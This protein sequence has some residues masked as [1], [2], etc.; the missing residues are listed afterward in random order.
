M[1]EI[2]GCMPGIDGGTPESMA[3]GPSL[4][5]QFLKPNH[6]SSSSN[7]SCPLSQ[8]RL[9]LCGT[10][11]P[12]ALSRAKLRVQGYAQAKVQG[13]AQAAQIKKTQKNLAGAQAV[14]EAATS[15]GRSRTLRLQ[16]VARRL[17]RVPEPEGR[18]GPN[19]SVRREGDA[20]GE[21]GVAV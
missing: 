19:A 17:R 9:G 11:W 6:D 5:R 20:Q 14:F 13:Y 3:A 2:D 1:P 15:R 8:S 16:G 12:Q 21:P 7:N 18:R 10:P 4:L